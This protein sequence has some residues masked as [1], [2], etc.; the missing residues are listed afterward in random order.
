MYLDLK[1]YK[2]RRW[3]STNVISFVNHKGSLSSPTQHCSDKSCKMWRP[4]HHEIRDFVIDRVGPLNRKGLGGN[5]LSFLRSETF[6][7]RNGFELHQYSNLYRFSFWRFYS[8]RT[9]V[10]SQKPRFDVLKIYTLVTEGSESYT[11]KHSFGTER[12]SLQNQTQNNGC[13]HKHTQRI[14]KCFRYL[15]TDGIPKA[16]TT[17][18]R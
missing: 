2:D 10:R 4:C 6:R 18:H 14:G 16:P 11:P 13:R 9:R 7:D 15:L 17:S 8:N 3:S 12:K 1:R 5:P